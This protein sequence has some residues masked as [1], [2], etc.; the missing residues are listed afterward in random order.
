MFFRPD[1]TIFPKV[2]FDPDTIKQRLEVSSYLHKGVKIAFEDE[3]R[4]E[5]R[6]F[7]HSEGLADYLKKIL[8]RAVGDAGARHA[9][10]A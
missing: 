4:K 7:Q 5:K 1:A 3:A 6:V 2:E 10:H 8:R 9:V